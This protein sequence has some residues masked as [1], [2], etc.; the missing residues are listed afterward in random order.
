MINKVAKHNQ[1]Y[2]MEEHGVNIGE[3]E[4]EYVSKD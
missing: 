3:F 1:G 4:L 2:P